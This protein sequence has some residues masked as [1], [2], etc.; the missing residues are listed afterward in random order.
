[1]A[2]LLPLALSGFG[3]CAALHRAEVAAVSSS[4]AESLNKKIREV[5]LDL[6]TGMRD[7]DPTERT[8]AVATFVDL[9]RMGETSSFGRFFAEQLGEE[10]YRLGF[11]VREWRQRKDVEVT[12]DKG[13]FYL[14]RNS[15]D[16]MKTAKV[17]AVVAGSYTVVGD[18]VVVN[19]RLLNVDTTKVMSVGRMVAYISGNDALAELLRRNLTRTMPMIKVSGGK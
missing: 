8:I 12:E 16:I 15:A 17:D 3:A 13:E 14:T 2:I 7:F 19:A 10:L 11:K 1:M 5:A 4:P 6:V 9:D 18:E